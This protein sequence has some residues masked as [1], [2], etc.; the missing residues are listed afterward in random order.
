[1]IKRIIPIFIFIFFITEVKAQEN[2]MIMKL[3]DGE[4]V[5][6]Y[7]VMLLQTM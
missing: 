6:N 2:I 3:K 1:M 5:L 7:L 4:V